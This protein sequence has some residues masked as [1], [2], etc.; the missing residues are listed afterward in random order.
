MLKSEKLSKITGHIIFV[1][2]FIFF[3]TLHAKNLDKYSSAENISDYFAGMLA[4]NESKYNDS[5]KYFKKLNGLEESHQN[6]S[7]KFLYSSIN[8]GNFNEAYNFSKTLER[9]NQDIFESNLILGIYYLRNSNFDLSKKY[10]LKAKNKKNL[11]ILDNYLLET[12]N[13][14][15]SLQNKE[16]ERAIFEIDKLDNRFNSLK[17]IQVVFV[18]CFLNS[19]KT[20]LLFENL[21]SDNETDYSRYY[22]FYAKYLAGKGEIDKS[23]K[24]LISSLKKF[25][26]NILLNQYKIDLENS[27]ES[28][29]FDCKNVRDVIAEL[30]YI[31]ANA[32][33]SQSI[34]S[35]SNF[36]IN[37]S[38]YLNT[39]FHVYDILMAE[40]F[41]KAD[42]I[43]E[44]KKIYQKL[45]KFGSA[46]EWHSNK[47]IS[48]IF[49]NNNE[50]DKALKLL[51][52]SYKE[53]SYKGLY[54]TF[55]LAEFLK[56][57]EEFEDA[58]IYY[59][60]ILDKI[61]ETHP[62]YPE[63]TDG[64]GVSYERIGIWEKAEIDLLASL[65]SS[66]DQAYVI[67]YLAYTWIEKGIKIEES[68]KMLEK[69]NR[70]KTN[71]PYIIDSLGWALFK[72]K[73]FK[74]SKNYL[75]TAVKLMPAD[76]IVNDHYGDV[77]WKN[78]N[79]IQARYYWK[80][81]LN[82]DETEKSLKEVIEKKLIKGL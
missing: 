18:N 75:Q 60:N 30:M 79:K 40:N 78:G 13:I 36:Y 28:F 76:P 47:Q 43:D 69:A 33:S 32:L 82:L 11:T 14:W 64:R 77:L 34:Y 37:L 3:S 31:A 52:K 29:D 5:L 23:K 50:K 39:K 44:A 62:L 42:D 9:D 7:A 10:F 57:S 35:L 59:S 22:Y 15:T 53:L 49:I 46:F 61:N 71:D 55:D 51:K 48:K 17:K 72:L 45:I 70:L 63:A 27:R 67:N 41:F 65:K 68:L 2:I 80:Y 54:D 4:L 1:I 6:Y 26:R 24:I 8:A 25:P 21:I 56:N 66:P 74:E 20:E 73:R 58:I 19:N 81:V 38:K 12:L 16:L